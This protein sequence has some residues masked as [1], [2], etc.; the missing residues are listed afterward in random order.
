[1][2]L[3]PLTNVPRIAIVN[4]MEGMNMKI[5]KQIIVKASLNDRLIY[6]RV[7]KDYLS[8]EG[9]DLAARNSK[10]EFERAGYTVM[11]EHV[12]DYLYESE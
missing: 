4:S 5:K 9:M 12:T 6:R 3:T 8:D 7:L 1:M 2:Y 11:M 10:R